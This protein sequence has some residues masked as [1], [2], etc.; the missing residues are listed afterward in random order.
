MRHPAKCRKSR[1]IHNFLVWAIDV[2]V[3]AYEN[4]NIT[5]DLQQFTN[6]CVVIIFFLVSRNFETFAFCN[7]FAKFYIRQSFRNFVNFCIIL[8]FC[9]IWQNCTWY[10]TT[11]VYS[12]KKYVLYH[13]TLWENFMFR[14]FLW[15]VDWS[16][17]K[18]H[19]K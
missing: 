7:F 13:R 11:S 19:V 2:Y 3:W 9:E 14:Y 8:Q 1:S 10:N 4:L 15:L 16:V 12:I 5:K 18:R 6:F 17:T